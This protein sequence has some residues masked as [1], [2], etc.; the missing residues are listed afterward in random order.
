MNQF[1]TYL[2]VFLKN[3]FLLN[4]VLFFNVLPNNML[5][6]ARSGHNFPRSASIQ[7]FIRINVGIWSSLDLD[8]IK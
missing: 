1:N 2:I 4:L 7:N 5:N 8:S 6:S 3:F